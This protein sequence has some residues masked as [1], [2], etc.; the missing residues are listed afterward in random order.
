M[1]VSIEMKVRKNILRE[2]ART[3]KGLTIKELA[4]ACGVSRYTV[5][6]V[7]QRLIGEKKVE[8]RKIGPAKL[9]YSK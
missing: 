2:L 9:H 3:N 1:A 6:K 4:K 5:A 8:V 7:L